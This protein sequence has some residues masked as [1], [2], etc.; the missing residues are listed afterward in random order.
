MDII[1]LF[2]ADGN[3]KKVS[4]DFLVTLVIWLL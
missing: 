1:F 2:S 4:A 3:L